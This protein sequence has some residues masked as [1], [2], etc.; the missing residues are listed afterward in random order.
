[1]DCCNG[2]YGP[3][4]RPRRPRSQPPRQCPQPG[5]RPEKLSARTPGITNPCRCPGWPTA[6]ACRISDWPGETGSTGQASETGNARTLV[7]A[8]GPEAVADPSRVAHP[9]RMADRA[10]HTPPRLQRCPGS[11]RQRGA[12]RHPCPRGGGSGR[13]RVPSGAGRGNSPGIPADRRV[14]CRA[15]ASSPACVRGRRPLHISGRH[16]MPGCGRPRH[17]RAWYSCLRMVP[18]ARRPLRV[19]GVPAV[20]RTRCSSACPTGFPPPTCCC[21]TLACGD[22]NGADGACGARDAHAHQHGSRRPAPARPDGL[23]RDRLPGGVLAAAAPTGNAARPGTGNSRAVSRCP[24]ASCSAVPAGATPARHHTRPNTTTSSF[25][26]AGP[27]GT[28]WPVPRCN[29]SGK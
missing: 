1:M 27:S 15:R 17:R 12:A 16:R 6:C 3:A 20:S 28:R 5:Q 26:P 11:L 25:P 9:A 21:R 14:G 8:H 29:A 4:G 22:K 18:A 19:P 2:R 7:S 10:P 23:L 13:S 24:M